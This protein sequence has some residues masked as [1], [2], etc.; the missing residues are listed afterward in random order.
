MTYENVNLIDFGVQVEGDT[1]K[2]Y[3]EL[4]YMNNYQLIDSTNLIS[5][6]DYNRLISSRVPIRSCFFRKFAKV[7]QVSVKGSVQNEDHFL[8]FLKLLK[9]LKRLEFEET[10]LSQS[11]FDRLPAYATSLTDLSLIGESELKLNFDFIFK[12]DQLTRFRAGMVWSFIGLVSLV[13]LFGKLPGAFKFHFLLKKKRVSIKKIRGSTVYRIC[14]DIF[15]TIFKTES[16]ND[17]VDA[18]EYWALTGTMRSESTR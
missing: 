14:N 8:W 11:F 6:L 2:V 3:D 9:S 12:L 13:K 10:E 17:I 7:S 16:T 4:I 1:E 18:I 15:E 5:S